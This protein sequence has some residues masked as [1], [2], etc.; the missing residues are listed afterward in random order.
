VPLVRAVVDAGAGRDRIGYRDLR[1]L[2]GLDP[3]VVEVL[4]STRYRIDGDLDAGT[5]QIHVVDQRGIAKTLRSRTSQN[6]VLKGTKHLVAMEK[7]CMVAKGRSDDRTV[8]IV[9]E[10]EQNRTTGITL[11]HARFHEHLPAAVLRA[12]LSGYRN[13]YA[14]LADAVTETEPTFDE[15]MLESMSVIDLLCEPIYSLADRWR[16]GTLRP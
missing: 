5:A 1:A 15:D 8:I 12:V 10:V 3:A 7:L 9:P 4:G 11:L 6:P 13:R 2:A 14:A 16:H